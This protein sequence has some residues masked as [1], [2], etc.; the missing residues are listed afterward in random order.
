MITLLVLALAAANAVWRNVEADRLIVEAGLAAATGPQAIIV[1]LLV[2]PEQYH[3][4]RLQARGTM[5]GAEGGAVRL[6]GVS[7][8]SLR[9][10]AQQPWVA[11]LRRLED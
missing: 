2:K 5:V 6:R 4:S 10:I 9:A 3:M 11:Q 7:P 1:E 8:Q